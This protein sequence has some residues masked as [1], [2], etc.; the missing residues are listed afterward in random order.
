MSE[1]TWKEKM[2]ALLR[3]KK[4]DMKDWHRALG[5]NQ[6]PDGYGYDAVGSGKPSEYL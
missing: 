5:L 1:K 3:Q 6:W 2:E 4:W